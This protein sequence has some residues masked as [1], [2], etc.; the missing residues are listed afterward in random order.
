MKSCPVCGATYDDSSIFCPV[1]G[2]TLRGQAEDGDLVGSVIAD[3]YLVLS[4]IGRGGMGHVYLAQHVRL[5]QKVAIKV[6][7]RSLTFESDAIMRFN[8]EAQHASSIS[9]EHVARIYDFGE[10]DGMAYIAMEFVEGQTLSSLLG[11]TGSLAPERVASI[12]SQIADGLDAAHKLGI[13]HRDLKPDNVLVSSDADGNDLVKVVDFGI[14]K[15]AQGGGPS[16]TSTG[17]AIGTAEFMSPEQ[18]AGE[19]VDRR[20]DV[21]ALGLVAFVLLTGR[22]PFQGPTK[23]MSMLM[24]L[25]QAPQSL[26]ESRP[27]ISWPPGIQD[28]ISRALAREVQERHQ[29]A[30]EFAR[31]L[32]AAIPS[33]AASGPAAAVVTP[34]PASAV[35]TRADGR[36]TRIVVLASAV[37]L[38]VLGVFALMNRPGDQQGAGGNAIA[39][40]STGGAPPPAGPDSTPTSEQKSGPKSVPTAPAPGTAVP[41]PPISSTSG[42][43]AAKVDTG[44]AVSVPTRGGA[45]TTGSAAGDSVANEEIRRTLQSIVSIDPLRFTTQSATQA[46]ADID[47]LLPR[48]RTGADSGQVEMIRIEALIFL[49]RGA[50]A[51]PYIN[52]L[53][54]RVVGDDQ[55]AL[56][57]YHT[58]LRCSGETP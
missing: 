33:R 4:L 56:R 28:A 12:I 27:D 35:A 51:C 41:G 47:R 49:D 45:N 23:E 25:T 24:R 7:H 19:L 13:V 32:A 37:V 34:T 16:L 39:G 58:N 21:Y 52:A 20:T 46:L 29:T 18:V 1:D 26:A 10:V 57:S 38:V 42:Q 3:R 9:N 31:S 36:R 11:Q 50:Q 17:M 14:A 30:G 8:R 54:P 22:L 53:L 44:G 6:L 48:L 15:A 43:T 40:G 55:R 5:P 2:A